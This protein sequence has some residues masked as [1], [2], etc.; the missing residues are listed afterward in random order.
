MIYG[1]F[2]TG[3]AKPASASVTAVLGPWLAS[4]G[5]TRRGR[6]ERPQVAGQLSAPLRLSGGGW[7][8]SAGAIV[9][10]LL[11]TYKLFVCLIQDR[12]RPMA[13]TGA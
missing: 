8:R 1:A 10:R 7:T 13:L 12:G 11:V 5:V 6:A 4:A 3:Q 9:D 2:A